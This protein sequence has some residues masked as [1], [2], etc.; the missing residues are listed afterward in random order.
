MERRCLATDQVWGSSSFG[1][2]ATNSY[3]RLGSLEVA[4]RQKMFI[5][6]GLKNTEILNLLRVRLLASL[7]RVLGEISSHSIYITL[8][9]VTYTS[10]ITLLNCNKLFQSLI[11]YFGSDERKNNTQKQKGSQFFLNSYRD[12]LKIHVLVD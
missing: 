5:T 3:Q 2:T 8:L 12:F 7:N 9:Y 11:K 6:V 1:N 10:F 4:A